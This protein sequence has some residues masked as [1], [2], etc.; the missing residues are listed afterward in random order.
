MDYEFIPID[1][2]RFLLKYIVLEI[3]FLKSPE[4]RLFHIKES[5]LQPTYSNTLF[6]Y[7]YYRV[8]ENSIVRLHEAPI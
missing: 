2:V 3:K 5:D 4:L 8:F 1:I 7:C 6:T